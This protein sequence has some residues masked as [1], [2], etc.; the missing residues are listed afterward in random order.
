VTFSKKAIDI[1]NESPKDFVVYQIN[2]KE[3]MD[4]YGK[5][6]LSDIMYAETAGELEIGIK[7]NSKITET[8]SSNSVEPF[9]LVYKLYDNKGNE[10]EICNRI[11]TEKGSYKYERVSFGGLKIDFTDN[12]LNTHEYYASGEGVYFETEDSAGGEKYTLEIFNPITNHSEK[13]VI[14]DNNTSYKAFDFEPVR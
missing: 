14:D 13:F 10:Y 3:F 1:Y 11:N 9:S 5:I 8:E 2:T 6:T 12:Y 4:Y 7:Y